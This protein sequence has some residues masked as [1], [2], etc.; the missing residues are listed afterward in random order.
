[1]KKIVSIII[2]LGLCGKLLS[3]Q[4]CGNPSRDVMIEYMTEKV[5]EIHNHVMTGS[6][7]AVVKKAMENPYTVLLDDLSF[8]TDESVCLTYMQHSDVGA[9]E[10]TFGFDSKSHRVEFDGVILDYVGDYED[11][12]VA[13]NRNDFYIH[14]VSDDSV[15]QYK[16]K[17]SKVK[18]IVFRPQGRGRRYSISMLNDEDF[19]YITTIHYD[20]LKRRKVIDEVLCRAA[21][22]GVEMNDSLKKSIS[23]QIA[24]SLF[25]YLCA[26]KV[27]SA[28]LKFEDYIVISET[29]DIIP[30]LSPIKVIGGYYSTKKSHVTYSGAI[31]DM[32][33]RAVSSMTFSPQC[34]AVLDTTF[35]SKVYARIPMVYNYENRELT[36]LF[37][38]G[39][40]EYKN[41]VKDVYATYYTEIFRNLSEAGYGKGEYKLSLK[42]SGVDGEYKCICQILKFKPLSMD[43]GNI[44]S[45]HGDKISPQFST[46]TQRTFSGWL[47]RTLRDSRIF[48]I[49]AEENWNRKDQERNVA[50]V[51]FT[52]SERGEVC[53][54]KIQGVADDALQKELLRVFL[55]SPQWTP[56]RVGKTNVPVAYS[57]PIYY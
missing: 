6:T 24:K 49:Y 27:L 32:I 37:H 8:I 54:V 4:S 42:V 53:N 19:Q 56:G 48:G 35:V 7:L 21:T 28:E 41:G 39:Y 34:V 46:M 14:D 29:G 36:V 55:S 57:M 17:F 43:K 30:Q 11:V 38:D 50:E 5:A 52:V 3:A 25:D 12:K 2:V 16:N 44:K 23:H 10:Y 15:A 18:A 47:N 20:S 26:N 13:L 22:E 51:S 40:L 9:T 31:E 1:M 45:P 33:D